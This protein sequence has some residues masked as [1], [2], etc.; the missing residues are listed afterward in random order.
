VGD[1]V[2][3]SLENGM[4]VDE[5]TFDGTAGQAVDMVGLQAP[6]TPGGSHPVPPL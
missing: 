6:T 2:A 3:E 5:L 1:T 4:D